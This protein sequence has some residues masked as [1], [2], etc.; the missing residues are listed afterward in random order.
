MLVDGGLLNNLPVDIMR[1]RAGIVIAIDIA[2]PVDLTVA[3]QTRVAFSGWPLLWNIINPFT[4]KERLPNIFSILSRAATLSSI[5][6]I[7][8]HKA[9]ADLYLH[10]IA[11][12]TDTLDFAAGRKLIG[13]G[14]RHA[15][16]EIEKW[17]QTGEVHSGMLRAGMCSPSSA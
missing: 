12:G 15:L 5:H 13:V 16:A 2:L 14:Y 11:T 1:S 9:G 6:N 4:K 3:S 8:A 17:K 7:D 10:P